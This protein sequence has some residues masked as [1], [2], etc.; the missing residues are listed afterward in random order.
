MQGGALGASQFVRLK[1]HSF[2]TPSVAQLGRSCFFF[3]GRKK[4]TATSCWRRERYTSL[5]CMQRWQCRKR[6]DDRMERSIYEAMEIIPRLS[7][8]R[9]SSV[10]RAN[11]DATSLLETNSPTPS[12]L[13]PSKTKG[14]AWWL[15]SLLSFYPWITLGPVQL[16]KR[17]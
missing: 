2:K 12:R 14:C 4:E 11:I 13:F 3:Q 1:Y 17:C 6:E 9:V 7:M 16:S 5:P 8:E 10:V 15:C